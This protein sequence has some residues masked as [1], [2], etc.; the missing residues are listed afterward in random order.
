MEVVSFNQHN[1]KTLQA[2]S[3]DII[4]LGSFKKI[5]MIVRELNFKLYY[6]LVTGIF[7]RIPS[8]IS[9]A[10]LEDNASKLLLKC[11]E[12]EPLFLFVEV[13]RSRFLPT[14]AIDMVRLVESRINVFPVIPLLCITDESYTTDDSYTMDQLDQQAPDFSEGSEEYRQNVVQRKLPYIR[15]RDAAES[16]VLLRKHLGNIRF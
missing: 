8:V 14:S 9:G 4:E 16:V 13:P 2:I 12:Y 15:V 6:E 1:E 5:L 3:Q 10:G 11:K 7:P